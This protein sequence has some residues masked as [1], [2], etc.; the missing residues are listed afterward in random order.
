MITILLRRHQSSKTGVPQN[1]KAMTSSIFSLSLRQLSRVLIGLVG[2]VALVNLT[3]IGII[4]H[5][6][7]SL[8]SSSSSF[9]SVLISSIAEHQT[10]HQQH[11]QQQL[12]NNLIED[13]DNDEINRRNNITRFNNPRI[14]IRGGVS[15]DHGQQKQQQ[16]R[17]RDSSPK[18]IHSDQQGLDDPQLPPNH[19][20]P[21]GDGQQKEE[22]MSACLLTMDDNHF[23]VEW[24]AYHYYVCRLRH[25]IVAIDPKSSRELPIEIFQR[26]SN[27]MT[28]EVW[29]DTSRPY[30]YQDYEERIQKRGN[31]NWDM[32]SLSDPQLSRHRER[33]SEFYF[34]C[35]TTLKKLGKGWT[36]LLDTDEYLHI[37]PKI[38]HPQSKLHIPKWDQLPKIQ[39]NEG[40]VLQMLLQL[41]FP[42]PKFKLNHPCVPLFRRQYSALDNKPS[43]EQIDV[44]AQQ[45]S[46]LFQQK[47]N[48]TLRVEQFQTVRWKLWG[49][50]HPSHPQLAGKAVIDLQRLRLSDI[51]HPQNDQSIDPH[52]I[53]KSICPQDNIFRSDDQVLLRVNHYMGTAE[54]WSSRINDARGMDCLID[55]YKHSNNIFGKKPVSKED[56]ISPWILGFVNQVGL[57]NAMT[58]LQDSGVVAPPLPK[59]SLQ[60]QVDDEATEKNLTRVRK[61]VTEIVSKV[62]P[63]GLQV[64]V[65]DDEEERW[66]ED[67]I[68]TIVASNCR[69]GYDIKFSNREW[70]WSCGLPYM[71]RVYD[72]YNNTIKAVPSNEE[73]VTLYDEVS[74]LLKEMLKGN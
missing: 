60:Q 61:L 14:K 57:K 51:H 18:R 50:K 23:L 72:E 48:H 36:F 21:D 59:G 56:D 52:L 66:W 45:L 69:G 49:N 32:E 37:N 42:S 47:M 74:Q 26:W 9:S 28:I 5:E 43:K 55:L 30:L 8:S 17:R 31:Q 13:E 19:H 38:H 73:E 12:E 39:E 35:I 29:D 46:I 40:S 22:S 4:Q 58:L 6:G 44:T 33:Q 34:E 68:G 1:R 71:K 67:D 11:E 63:I 64:V 25:L 3:M 10:H 62:V 7:S 15:D 16:Q 41:K 65:Y 27:L 70:E 2:I 20:H 24:I 54:Q 53:L